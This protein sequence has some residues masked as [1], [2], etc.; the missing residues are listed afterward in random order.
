MT[1]VVHILWSG[2][3]SKSF[4]DMTKVVFQKQGHYLTLEK[5]LDLRSEVQSSYK[6]APIFFVAAAA[7]TSSKVLAQKQRPELL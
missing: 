3:V 2:S 1:V 6:L 7:T 4:I 5:P